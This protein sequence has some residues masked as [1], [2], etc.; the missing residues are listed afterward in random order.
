MESSTNLLSEDKKTSI[1]LIT[2]GNVVLK[3]R[4][5]SRSYAVFQSADWIILG[6]AASEAKSPAEL[7]IFLK[8]SIADW[9]LPAPS[10]K[11]ILDLPKDC[12]TDDTNIDSAIKTRRIK[13]AERAEA[14]TIMEQMRND[15]I[16]LR[17]ILVFQPEEYCRDIHHL[18]RRDATLYRPIDKSNP[19]WVIITGNVGYSITN[20][21]M[22]GSP[23]KF[24]LVTTKGFNAIETLRVADGLVDPALAERTMMAE[25]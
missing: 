10:F 23:V 24:A 15:R 22:R 6:V 5:A 12:S 7:K 19:N 2:T 8:N 18:R 17:T 25:P 20:R 11:P 21:Q 4:K 16:S 1:G 14:E 3:G 13:K 9:R